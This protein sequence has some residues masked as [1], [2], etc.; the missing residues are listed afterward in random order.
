MGE[1]TGADAIVAV[2]VAVAAGGA[3]NAAAAA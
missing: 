3:R 1:S 2:A